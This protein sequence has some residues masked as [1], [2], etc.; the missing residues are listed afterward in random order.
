MAKRNL[1]DLSKEELI[2]LCE[3]QELQIKSYSSTSTFWFKKHQSLENKF[4]A[5]KNII[6][7]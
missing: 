7:L 5:I 1:E 3:K 2:E 4:N 6:E